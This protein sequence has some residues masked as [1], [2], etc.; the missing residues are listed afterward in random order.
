MMSLLLTLNNFTNSSSVHTVDFQ[1]ENVGWVSF[2]KNTVFTYSVEQASVA[3][4][5]L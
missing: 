2:N 5:K 1:H 3:L 4:A